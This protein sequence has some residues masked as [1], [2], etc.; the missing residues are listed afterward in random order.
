MMDKH[1]VREIITLPII[2]T[3]KRQSI[4]YN[5]KVTIY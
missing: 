4:I 5:G 2:A 3:V 1:G